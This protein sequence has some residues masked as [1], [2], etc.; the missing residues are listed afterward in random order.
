MSKT[1]LG[2]KQKPASSTG[3][4]VLTI[5]FGLLFAAL[6]ALGGWLYW[7]DL[8]KDKASLSAAIT[9]ILPPELM[10]SRSIFIERWIN[11]P[12]TGFMH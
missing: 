4:P 3:A 10:S 6:A 9:T 12:Q 8:Q 5:L 2:N 7:S 11:T 1:K